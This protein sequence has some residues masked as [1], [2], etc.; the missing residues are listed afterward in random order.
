MF[1]L[2]IF[3]LF[4]ALVPSVLLSFSSLS[5]SQEARVWTDL[6]LYGGHVREIAIDPVNP[7]KMFA[8]TYMGD[9]L[10]VTEDGGNNWQATGME[11]YSESDSL[12]KNFVSSQ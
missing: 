1:R 4:V 7:D 5:F 2:S 3:S 9:G 10:F 12:F 11:D 6:G 8:A